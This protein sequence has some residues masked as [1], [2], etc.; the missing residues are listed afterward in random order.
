MM[1][2][3]NCRHLLFFRGVTK[4]KETNNTKMMVLSY[5]FPIGEEQ[6]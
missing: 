6:E 3:T 5:H 1:M 4:A 2:M